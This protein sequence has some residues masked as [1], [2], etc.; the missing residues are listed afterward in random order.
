MLH[1]APAAP[2][3]PDCETE[4]KLVATSAMLRRLRRLPLLGAASQA[5]AVLQR[6][7]YFDTLA[8][9]LSLAGASLRLRERAGKHEQTLKLAQAGGLERA[10]WNIPLPA[11]AGTAQPDLAALP[12]RART[13]LLAAVGAHPLR[14]F[15]RVEVMRETRRVTYA[16]AV[17]E[18]AFDTGRIVP[19]TGCGRHGPGTRICELEL[20]L[21][22]GRLEAVLALAASLP[23]GPDL[24]WQVAGKAERAHALA[25][26][27]PLRAAR[28][29]PLA[30]S[31]DMPAGDAFRAIG[32]NALVHLLANLPL[33]AS[34]PEAV[35]QARVALR[36]LRAAF[37]L[38]APLWADGDGSASSAS[39]GPGPAH[40]R[41][42]LGDLARALGP[43]RDLHVLGARLAT[44]PATPA[45]A[46][47]R[48]HLAACETQASARAASHIASAPTQALL[49]ALAGWL[50]SPAALAAPAAR[51]PLM[52]FAGPLLAR[53][54][55]HLR[56]QRKQLAAL[57]EA[58]LHRLRIQVKK[59][60]YAVGFLAPAQSTG[61]SARAARRHEGVL[62]RLQE[63]LGGLNDLAVAARPQGPLSAAL[64]EG[65]PPAEAADMARLL[66]AACR[67]EAPRRKALL[68]EARR[69]LAEE[70]RIAC[71]WQAQKE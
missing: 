11:D 59:L 39:A 17:I 2:P 16:G 35:H 67:A 36:R 31:P 54:R 69:L 13:A 38:F 43:A 19:L 3:R 61:G 49:M 64:A 32:W 7:T 27:R 24:M 34:D 68:E 41:A 5:G 25:Y 51:Q 60:R 57:P 22:S 10:E 40:W 71:W 26:D 33:V 30:L 9:S 28:A 65:L 58:S 12:P 20:E 52:A 56:G 18:L 42:A 23:L 63:V 29:M 37:A 8:G 70:K 46:R 45:M 6:S 55:R 66:E 4:I 50:E 14:P 1:K 15:A 53:R 48:Q 21:V 44:A 62:A 47:L